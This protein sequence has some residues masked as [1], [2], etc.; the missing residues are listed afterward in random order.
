MNTTYHPIG[1]SKIW[2]LKA[3]GSLIWRR[4]NDQQDLSKFLAVINKVK[5]DIIHIHGTEN[6]FGCLIP[7][8]KIPVVI[9]MQGC[10]TVIS[11]KYL[12]GFTKKDLHL[13]RFVNARRIKELLFHRSFIRA[14]DELKRNAF[15]E[16]RNLR[17]ASYLIG[18]TSWDRRVSSVLA[19]GSRYFH[20]NEILRE[21][22]YRHVWNYSVADKIIIHTTSASSPFKGLLT[23]C[24]AVSILISIDGFNFEWRIAGIDEMDPIVR[25][26][27]NKLRARD[28]FNRI[29]FKGYMNEAELVESLCNSHMYVS[30]SHIENSSNSL[31]EAMLIG[32]PCIATFSGGTG[33]IISDG[34][35]GILVQDG[36]PWTLAG[37]ILELHRNSDLAQQIGRNAR[38]KALVRHNP[39]KIVS[40]LQMVYDN[41][42]TTSANQ[43]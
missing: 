33:S 11:H 42:I 29:N 37:A 12:N 36:D 24:Q 25:I 34:I 41:I 40:D 27:R 15:R 21:T 2:K 1:G 38:S 39:E 19:P 3:L 10:V 30:P 31:G 32:M 5:P 22:F 17:N 43:T 4:Y 13:N 23:I 26:V 35:D 9:S 16:Q 18:R 6:P 14:A 7:F 20:C 8:T 28:V